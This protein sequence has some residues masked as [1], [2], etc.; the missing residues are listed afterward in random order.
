MDQLNLPPNTSRGLPSNA[1]ALMQASP[2]PW[3]LHHHI[4]PLS[5]WHSQPLPLGSFYFAH[6]Q[7]PER[8]SPDSTNSQPTQTRQHSAL[9]HPDRTLR[10]LQHPESVAGPPAAPIWNSSSHLMSGVGRYVS[11]TYYDINMTSGSSSSSDPSA[12][13]NDLAHPTP[14]MRGLALQPHS[15]ADW[16][17]PVA[18]STSLLTAARVFPSPG[19]LRNVSDPHAASLSST[20]LSHP[21]NQTSPLGS[22]QIPSPGSQRTQRSQ[23]SPTIFGYRDTSGLPSPTSDRRR[24]SSTRSRRPTASSQSES[25][26]FRIHDDVEAGHN[27]M[28]ESPA[29]TSRVYR[30]ASLTDDL[31]ARQI[32][33]FRG[34]LSSKLVASRVA[35]QS[36][37]RLETCSLKEN[38][39]TCVIC[40]NDYGVASPEGVVETAVRLPLCKHIFGYHCIKKWLEDSDSCPYCRSKLQPESKHVPGS[41]RTFL[42]MMRVRGLPLPAGLSDEVMNRL[43][44]RPITDVEFQ[45]LFLR[46]ARTAERRPPPDDSATQEQRRTRQRRNGPVS[47]ENLHTDDRDAQSR[48]NTSDAPSRQVPTLSRDFAL[49]EDSRTAQLTSAASTSSS[50]TPHGQIR[51]ATGGE[52][53]QH[54]SMGAERGQAASARTVLRPA[55]PAAPVV[56]NSSSLRE[57]STPNPLLSPIRNSSV[58]ST[59]VSLGTYRAPILSAMQ[60][61][62]QRPAEAELSPFQPGRIRPW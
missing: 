43:A 45:E 5:P 52:H 38:E 44:T 47:E 39:K 28:G 2:D 29:P 35:I 34:T 15:A 3:M 12:S 41:A 20:M 57:R 62:T 48:S 17:P 50:T 37:E 24:Q 10:A 27:S 42:A 30:R 25:G 49:T 56:V 46:A 18:T 36:L 13:V 23:A 14:G 53:T 26:H 16:E 6:G 58:P 60:S 4:S 9:P 61:Q 51:L 59:S 8:A 1:G 55:D 11:G 32:Q 40:Y 21:P 7:S 54:N 19:R 22:T 33:V 31:V